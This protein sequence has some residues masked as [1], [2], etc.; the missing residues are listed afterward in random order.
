[1]IKFPWSL[2]AHSRFLYFNS[3]ETLQQLS[4]IYVAST[5]V[6]I[7]MNAFLRN[8]KW[9][10][11]DF[12]HECG[13][14]CRISS[15]QFWFLHVPLVI[16]IPLQCPAFPC[17]CGCEKPWVSLHMI[18]NFYLASSNDYYAFYSVCSLQSMDSA[19]IHKNWRVCFCRLLH[20]PEKVSCKTC[21]LHIRFPLLCRHFP[22]QTFTSLMIICGEDPTLSLQKWLIY[23]YRKR[24]QLNFY[25][26]IKF[27]N[28]LFRLPSVNL[29]SVSFLYHF[30]N[31][32]T[33]S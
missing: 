11:A 33:V 20:V 12:R 8:M 15:P 6:S 30:K 17:N 3:L 2:A 22:L 26:A 27:H 28:M 1:M 29:R 31:A 32:Q 5:A 4:W 19:G 24:T 16:Q 14:H 23:A 25:K 13:V 21:R 10:P 7:R 9:S 18:E